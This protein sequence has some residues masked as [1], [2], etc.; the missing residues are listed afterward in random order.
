MAKT[1][2]LLRVSAVTM[3]L[4]LLLGGAPIAVSGDDLRSDRH[5]PQLTEKWQV[6]DMKPFARQQRV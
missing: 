2:S 6:A 4:S 5:G 3:A 1:K